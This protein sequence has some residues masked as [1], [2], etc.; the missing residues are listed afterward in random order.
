MAR[1][2]TEWKAAAIVR[3]V[4]IKA[5]HREEKVRET[6]DN[7]LARLQYLRVRDLPSFLLL[8]HYASTLTEEFLSLLPTEE[9]VHEWFR[10]GE[11]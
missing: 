11:E 10:G 9:E 2:F 7:L 4:S 5:A 8:L 1:S 3:L 6:V